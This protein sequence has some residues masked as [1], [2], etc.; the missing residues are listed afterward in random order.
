MISD[1]VKLAKINARAARELK[2]MELAK[3]VITNPAVEL[4]LAA[5]IVIQMR[6]H[7]LFSGLSG[8]VEEASLMAFIAGCVGLQ[9]I[10]P[11]AP[12][13][14]QGAEGIGKAIPSLLSLAAMA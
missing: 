12:A 9:Q 7:G 3:A 14:A 10:A 8:G 6:K 13:I 2:A 1:S 5:Y 11:L 4:I